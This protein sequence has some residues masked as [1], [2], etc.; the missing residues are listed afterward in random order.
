MAAPAAPTTT[1]TSTLNRVLDNF[2]QLHGYEHEE[3][4]ED[5]HEGDPELPEDLIAATI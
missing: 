1:T 2:N 5:I 4:V 3:N